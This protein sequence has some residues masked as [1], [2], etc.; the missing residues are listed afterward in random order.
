M[1]DAFRG[2]PGGRAQ[3]L[4]VGAGGQAGM[5]GRGL[6]HRADRGD[7]VD[8]VP[9]RPA[10][11]GGRPRVRGDQAEDHAQR[12]GLPRAVGAEEGRDRAG[13]DGERQVVHGPHGPEGLAETGDGDG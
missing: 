4:Q 13:P 8:E 10:A 11:D 1:I 9:V 3:D 12:G 5:E 2:E 7:R 6:Q